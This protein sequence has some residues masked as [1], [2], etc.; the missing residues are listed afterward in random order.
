LSAHAATQVRNANTK[1]KVRL[2]TARE[3][4][5]HLESHFCTPE[6]EA[7]HA[8]NKINKVVVTYVEQTDIPRDAREP[9]YDTLVGQKSAFSYLPLRPGVV[10]S[11]GDSCWCADGC[12]RARGPG[13][14]LVPGCRGTYTVDGCTSGS[15][16]TE[17][18]VARNDLAGIGARRVQAQSNGHKRAAKLHGKDAKEAMDGIGRFILVQA[19]ERWSTKEEVHFR[20]GHYWLARTV[21]SSPGSGTCIVEKVEKN[22]FINGNRFDRGDYVI[23]VEWFDREAADGDGLSFTK[24][25]PDE[26]EDERMVVNSTELRAVEGY[27]ID[28]TKTDGLAF[29]VLRVEPTVLPVL[30]P[31]QTGKVAPRQQ[32]AR[33]AKRGGPTPGT[34][35]ALVVER[36][37][38]PPPTPETVWEIRADV[39]AAAR[40]ECW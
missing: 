24:W 10:L 22:K 33:G 36:P 19:R 40:K 8:G 16:W 25:V 26:D 27:E 30:V 28:L 20:Q 35:A 2:T 23:A 37:L 39:D 9:S 29:S 7:K 5:A 11:K 6:W 12:M 13:N 31:P 14:G 3:A 17:H 38:P 21:E 4:A 15:K 32:A 18:V 34:R 1:G